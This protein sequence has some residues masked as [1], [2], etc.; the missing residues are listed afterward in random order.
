MQRG[1]FLTQPE[2]CEK[3]HKNLCFSL[4][5]LLDC[6]VMLA[7][8]SRLFATSTVTKTIHFFPGILAIAGITVV[9]GCSRK[10]K[11]IEPAPPPRIQ[12]TTVEVVDQ[13]IPKLLP[14][15]GTVEAVL[16]T[17]L[18]ANASG[19]VVWLHAERG[20]TVK[21]GEPLVKLDVQLAG[22][23]AATAR[24]QTQVSTNQAA[25]QAQ[26]CERLESLNKAGA[27]ARA[28]YEKQ[29]WQCKITKEA[30]AVSRLQAE[31]ATK[32]VRDGIIRAPFDGS[33]VA[34]LVKL[35]GSV[36]PTTPVV[37]MVSLD[38]LKLQ[39]TVPEVYL[40]ALQPGQVV[41]FRVAG[42]PKRTFSATLVRIAPV[43]RAS[44]RDVVAEAEVIN[45]DH[46]LWPGMF[47]SADLPVGMEDLPTV[48]QS[49]VV[50]QDSGNHVFVV[51]EG[52]IEERAVQL[53]PM[54]GSQVAIRTG[55]NKGDRVV[56]KPTPET[57]NGAFVN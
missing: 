21:Q 18:A 40:S 42:Y 22:L 2:K 9:V 13:S 25:L 53:G 49:A 32:A 57:K 48:P 50:T 27:M 16:E 56:S 8:R 29:Q 43:V 41:T 44:T 17:D 35:G 4:P 24:A 30:L 6:K 3:G 28:E 37:T 19:K 14:V 36:M 26:E 33:I 15:T 11:S 20:Q 38:P 45:P 34:R 7:F 47:A 5:R 23:Q 1:R 10:D 12:V 39:L 54:L 31:V 52:R 51:H 55:V 46:K